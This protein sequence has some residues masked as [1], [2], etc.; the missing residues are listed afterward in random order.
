LSGRSI[1]KSWFKSN[2]YDD[3]D[4]KK[5]TAQQPASQAVVVQ[6]ARVAASRGVAVLFESEGVDG[7]GGA[8]TGGRATQDAVAGGVVD[9]KVFV[10]RAGVPTDKVI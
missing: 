1:Q 3:Y 5:E 4:K 8:T 10:G 9:V 7:H 2:W 6:V